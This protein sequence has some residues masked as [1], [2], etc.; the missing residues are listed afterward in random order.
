M[1]VLS[2]IFLPVI[3][4]ASLAVTAVVL[5]G[6]F[7]P[8]ALAANG[9]STAISDPAYRLLNERVMANRTSFFVYQDGDSAL[10]H[11]FPSGWYG[12]TGKIS[13]DAFCL[14]D[15]N[16]TNGC[17]ADARLLKLDRGT[18]LRITFSPL[19]PGEFAGVNI[20]EPENYGVKQ[21]AGQAGVGYDLTGATRLVFDVRSATAAGIWVKF[22][23]GGRTTDFMHIAYSREYTTR[24][25]TLDS[26]GSFEQANTHIVFS[27]V[28]N[29]RNAPNG[30]TLLLDNIR[31]EPVPV[32]Q[33]KVVGFPVSTQTY[34]ILPKQ[35]ID[36]S[37]VSI[38]PD[39]VLRNGAM[40]YSSALTLLALLR[41]GTEDDLR[42]ARVIADAFS[43]ALRHDNRVDALPVAPQGGIGFHSAYMG[44]DVALFNDQAP[45]CGARGDVRLAGFTASPKLCQLKACGTTG[46]CVLLNGA[47]GGNNAF[48]VLALAAA[49]RRFKDERYLND[50]RTIGTW[51]VNNLADISGKG[52]AGYHSGYADG[53]KKKQLGKSTEQN[54]D[55]FA[56][57]SM[58]ADIDREM[59]IAGSPWAR[60]ADEAAKFVVAMY[61]QA[62][63]GFY[64]G[65]VPKDQPFAPGIQPDGPKKGDEVTNSYDFLDSNSMA[66]LALAASPS[67]RSQ[68][69]WRGPV[70]W[71]LQRFAKTITVGSRKFQGLAL[72]HLPEGG[73]DGIDWEFTAQAIVAMRLVDLIYSEKKFEKQAD[74]YLAQLR[75]AQIS[76]PFS[77]TRGL[78]ANTLQDGDRTDLVPPAEHC[79][80]TPFQCIPQRVSLA[81]TAW[82]VFAELNFNPFRIPPSISS[83]R[84][85]N[86]AS[87]V[88]APNNVIA[89][90]TI[91]SIFGTG[92]A[93]TTASVTALSDGSL[94]RAL[95]GTG[96]LVHDTCAP[97]FYVSPAQ[98]NAQAPSSLPASG[99]TSVV[100]TTGALAN[101]C[102]LGVPG[103]PELVNTAAYSPGLFTSPYGRGTVVGFCV[104]ESSWTEIPT[105]KLCKCG[106]V[107]VVFGTGFGAT[108]PPID[109]GVAAPAANRLA[110]PVKVTIGGV[111][112]SGF[113]VLYA[114]SAP[115]FAGLY[116]FN[117]RI[118]ENVPTGNPE[119][120]ICIEDA[121][122]QPGATLPV[123]PCQQ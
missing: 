7:A 52:F 109:A 104:D 39:Q 50:A 64:A 30:G 77:D 116:Q 49:Y 25:I 113:Q 4:I 2:R 96:V 22:G 95:G 98:I 11:G 82:A 51:I 114:G 33:Q 97:L 10:N 120:R 123:S 16:A 54:A 55:I 60:G 57:F 31:F 41:R 63:G 90:N 69:D 15:P 93:D 46:F 76:A 85:M 65:T 34:G 102:R 1:R 121:C 32:S 80:S 35:Q 56:A 40:V 110:K 122:S 26:L 88:P 45:G 117:L 13:V 91:I 68:I 20:E 106:N 84:V 111:E 119:I 105:S 29:D 103:L 47:T 42:S 36:Q 70:N 87:F 118:P 78:V 59:G 53:D 74:L 73:P 5:L 37:R 27:V 44:G 89:P 8:Y 12:E 38:P 6:M 18:V 58:L 79:K 112:V 86:G 66:L 81:A 28:T 101:D 67:Y 21:A 19:L 107:T 62:K 17:S 23:V 99:K 100:V 24:L 94:P 115:G 9:L 72:V 61:D 3:F 71:I 14:D 92:L 43:Y 75:E 108:D 83:G 48:V